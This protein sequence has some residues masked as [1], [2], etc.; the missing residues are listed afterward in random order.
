MKLYICIIITL[1]SIYFS[2]AQDANRQNIINYY[3]GDPLRIGNQWQL[4]TDES[5][6]EDRFRLERN[7][8]EISKYP[9]NPILVR[10]KPWE[11]DIIGPVSVIWDPEWGKYRMWYRAFNLSSYFGA[12]GPPYYILYAESDDGFNWEKPL[13]D[14]VKMPGFKRTNVIYTGTYYSRIQGVQV[15]RDEEERDRS[16]RYKMVSLERRPDSKGELRSGVQIAYSKDGL[17]WKLDEKETPLLNYHSDCYNHIVK[18]PDNEH[19]LL[20]CR[21]IILNAGDPVRG[22]RSELNE[23]VVGAFK[24]HSGRRV[25]VSVSSDFQNWSFPRT[26]LYGDERDERDI[27]QCMV[28]PAGSGLIMLYAALDGDITGQSEIKLASSSDGFH[29]TR[30]HE[31]KP[32]IQKGQ[33]GS[34]DSGSVTICGQPVIHG[35]YML[36]YYSGDNLGQHEGGSKGSRIGSI[37]VAITKVNRFVVQE[38]GDNPGF[39]LTKEFI[40]EGN[41]LLVNTTG[42]NLPNRPAPELRV[43]ILQKESATN[44]SETVVPGFSLADCDVIRGDRNEVE[45]TWN[46]NG[47][48]D[49]LKGESVYLRFQLRNKGL[50]AFKIENSINE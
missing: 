2:F 46:G 13:M 30:Y 33:E 11:G 12:E 15:W 32:Y 28:F 48:L 10:D 6:I 43:E 5:I 20:F 14:R 39:L 8:V 49:A 17:E 7:L 9:K 38:A 36:I 40:L 23:N 4:L 29:W 18:S 24:Q 35:E 34:W 19:W 37:G 31:R 45:V 25:S 42:P 3:L 47:N 22:K 50:C 27:D 21:P 26:V 44:A 16:K 1:F 41:R